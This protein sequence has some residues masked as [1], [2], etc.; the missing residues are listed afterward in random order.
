MDAGRSQGGCRTESGRSQDGVRAE[1]GRSQG[2]VRTE[3]GRSQGG[4]KG[5]LNGSYCEK[6][7]FQHFCSSIEKIIPHDFLT[8]RL[9]QMHE[10]VSHV[11][12]KLKKTDQAVK[13][14]EKAREMMGMLPD[15]ENRVH[16]AKV[17]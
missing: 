10:S 17:R 6:E 12:R 8:Q 4:I 3:S 1:S 11:Y 9:A 16:L 13:H 7:I 5:G 14:L 2:G 15:E